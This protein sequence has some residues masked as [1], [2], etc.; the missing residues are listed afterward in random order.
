MLPRYK[1][2]QV[3]RLNKFGATMLSPSYPNLIRTG[4][5][6]T[7]AYD[8]FYPVQDSPE[9]IEYWGYDILFGDKLVTM[10]PEDFIER[11]KI[12][13]ENSE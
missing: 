10:I 5:V 1:K 4:L 9:Y 12:D 13:E 2:G 3:V 8:I 7:D 6:I 11:I